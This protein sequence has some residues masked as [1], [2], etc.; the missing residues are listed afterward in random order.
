[1][2]KKIDVV[3]QCKKGTRVTSESL[4]KE[5]LE[6]VNAV[7]R[8]RFASFRVTPIAESRPERLGEAHAM[9]NEGIEEIRNIYDELQD[10]LDGMPDSFQGGEKAAELE[11][12][13]D[14]LQSVV[15]EVETATSEID[16]ISIPGMY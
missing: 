9:I 16:S 2:K 3:I 6:A 15:D 7:E 10:W 11:D 12:T 1:M 13:V 5:V 14:Q 8:V 4:R